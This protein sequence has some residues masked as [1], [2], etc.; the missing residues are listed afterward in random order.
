MIYRARYVLTMAQEPIVDGEVLVRNGRIEAVGCNL[1]NAFPNERVTNFGNAAIIPG[2]V[3]LHTHLDWTIARGLVDGL[4]FF[5]WVRRLTELG[6]RLT[7]D[8]FLASARLG[9]LA[10]VRSGVTTTADSSYSGAS[11]K[12]LVEA[13]LRGVV[14]QETFGSD[15]SGDY[16]SRSIELREQIS[17]LLELSGKRIGIGVSP[18]SVYTASESVLRLVAELAR[19]MSL[20]VAVHVSETLEENEFISTATGP[21]ADF[22]HGLRYDIQARGKTPVEYLREVGLLGPG[23]IAAHCVHV[24]E[25]DIGIISESGTT[26]AHCPKSNAKLAVG[27]A[28]ISEIARSGILTGIGTD[29]AASCDSLD[30]FEE[31]RAAVLAQRALTGDISSM[32]TFRALQLA[33]IGGA[34]ALGLDSEIGTIEVGKRADM[35]A[36]DF[37]ASD[38]YSTADP[39]ST[40]VYSLSASDVVMTMIEGVEVYRDGIYT[41]VDASEIRKAASNSSAKLI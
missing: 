7:Y 41:S 1:Q 3:N 39:C 30:M 17:A 18:H 21:I 24:S 33:T 23:T 28:P 36:V 29:S 25:G 38:G 13:G 15:P 2:F 5:P 16:H 4:T 22:Y 27:I 34:N 37:S 35:V 9:A 6:S 12:A 31:M 8:D 20:P 26:V 14:F 11:V 19:D 10:L 32:D 40:I